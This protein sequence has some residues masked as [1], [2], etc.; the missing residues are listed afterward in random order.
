MLISKDKK[1]TIENGAQLRAYLLDHSADAFMENFTNAEEKHAGRK[2]KSENADY[3]KALECISIQGLSINDIMEIYQV[4]Q[5]TAYR[6]RRQARAHEE[7]EI[8]KKKS[9]LLYQR[10]LENIDWEKTMKMAAAFKTDSSSQK[11]KHKPR[12]FS[13]T[14]STYQH[15]LEKKIEMGF[16]GSLSDFLSYIID[17]L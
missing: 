6:M 9:Y 11:E 2:P 15:L 17:R 7:D 14:D 13:I 3:I 8:R 4:S 1:T 10:S 12:S 5:A 16:E